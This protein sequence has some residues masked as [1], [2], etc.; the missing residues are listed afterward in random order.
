MEKFTFAIRETCVSR[1]NGGPIKVPSLKP[2]NTIVL[3]LPEGFQGA[4]NW[5]PWCRETPASR[6]AVRLMVFYSSRETNQSPAERNKSRGLLNVFIFDVFA[7]IFYVLIYIYF[8][9]T[10]FYLS[11][12]DVFIYFYFRYIYFD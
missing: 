2:I 10:Y 1:H 6:T 7:F 8:R 3:W 5:T 11:I 4:L 12:F 9:C